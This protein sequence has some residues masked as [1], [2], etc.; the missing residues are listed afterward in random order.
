[1]AL[2]FGRKSTE[3]QPC[4]SRPGLAF[5][6]NRRR[7]VLPYDL[8]HELRMEIE[9][10]RAE[11]DHRIAKVL[12]TAALVVQAWL[13]VWVFVHRDFATVLIILVLAF[14]WFGFYPKKK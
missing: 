12:W 13:A 7:T 8:T 10:Q 14:H 5:S 3:R 4:A 11:R 9:K 6:E 2:F 1:M